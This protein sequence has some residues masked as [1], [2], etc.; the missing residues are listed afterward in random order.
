MYEVFECIAADDVVSKL[1]SMLTLPQQRSR[2]LHGTARWQAKLEAAQNVLFCKE[3]F[4]QV[5]NGD[6][7]FIIIIIII[8]VFIYICLISFT[9]LAVQRSLSAQLIHPTYGSKQPSNRSCK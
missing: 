5:R 8:I 6:F 1:D 3:L 2:P 7:I 4:S 9:I